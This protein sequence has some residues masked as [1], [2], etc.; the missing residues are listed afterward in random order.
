MSRHYVWWA[1]S[2]ARPYD[3]V[4]VVMTCLWVKMGK[5]MRLSDWMYRERLNQAGVSRKLKIS[6]GHVSTLLKN[7]IWPSRD[8]FQ[9]IWAMTG[10]EV[11]PNDFLWIDD[12]GQMT[13]A[14]AKTVPG[15]EFVGLM[16]RNDAPSVVFGKEVDL[17]DGNIFIA[18]VRITP[19]PE[20]EDD[21]D[22]T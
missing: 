22:A 14:E 7:A 18:R 13:I 17:W 12:D 6:Q 21:G 16:T 3:V 4:N 8:L 1:Q 19:V 9:R 10:G 5:A 15:P 20:K 11:T 2:A